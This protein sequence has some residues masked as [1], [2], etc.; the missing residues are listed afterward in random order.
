M[1][2]FD[3]PTLVTMTAPTCSGKSHLLNALT[4]DGRFSRIVST[5]TRAKRPGEVEGVDYHFIDAETSHRMEANGEFFELIT[6]NGTR[7]GVTHTEM[8]AKMTGG[9]APIVILEPQG[10]EIYEQKCREHGWDIFKIYVHVTEKVQLERL[11]HRSLQA[12]WRS[13]DALNPTPGRYTQAFFETGSDEAKKVLAGIINEHQRRLL[14]IT[15]A[16]RRWLNMYTWDA[17]VPGDSVEKAAEMI[18]VGVKWR[19]RKMGAP[20]AIGAVRLPL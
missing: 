13:I 19:N 16:E 9:A 12:S 17:I 2:K 20:V 15:G 3:R 10:L 7:Y 5:T 8:Q 4:T 14:S 1:L 18:E 6:F 11:L